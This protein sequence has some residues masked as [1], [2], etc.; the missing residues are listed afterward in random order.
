MP[1]PK[2]IPAY[3]L[4]KASGQARVIIDG[5]HV[6]LGRYGSPES[7]EEYG[8][9][10]AENLQRNLSR[11]NATNGSGR[12]TNNLSV[13]ELISAYVTFAKSYYVENGIP[14]KEV[15]SIKDAL[16]PLRDGVTL[17]KH[18]LNFATTQFVQ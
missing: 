15:T 14:T 17:R 10:I 1:R 4:H 3:K 5:R 18:A 8:R 13:N 6:Y 9:V 12:P 7:H 2:G 11:A 16:K